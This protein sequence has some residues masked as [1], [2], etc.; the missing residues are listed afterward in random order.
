VTLNWLEPTYVCS[1]GGLK[2]NSHPWDELLK[3][4]GEVRDFPITWEGPG[5]PGF[6]APPQGYV[7][8][9]GSI[10]KYDVIGFAALR[11]DNVL[12][13][14]QAGPSS[15]TSQ[16]PWTDY[17]ATRVGITLNSVLPSGADVSYTW[18]GHRSNGQQQQTGGSCAFTTTQNKPA[19]PYTW[20]VFGG[21]GGCP[22]NNDV[23]DA[24]PNPLTITTTVVTTVDG[25]CGPVP[26]GANGNGNSSARCVLVKWMGSTVTGDYPTDRLEK[27]RIVRLCDPSLGNCLDQ[28]SNLAP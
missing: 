23:V 24:T 5:S 28:R 14:Q 16:Q 9:S 20:Q 17:S 12:T 22:G 4:K 11:I 13:V 21:G 3:L 7:L 18:T 2:G 15:S 8:H 1:T 19:G 26:S 27:M 6:G 10:L 25:P